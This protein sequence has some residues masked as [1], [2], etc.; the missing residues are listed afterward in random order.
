MEQ[1]IKNA[2]NTIFVSSPQKSYETVLLID[3]FVGSGA[4]L[5]IMAKKLKSMGY[6]KKIVAISLLGNIDTGY[7]VINEV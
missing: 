2:E 4:T 7:D 5:N 1:R 6:A 3:D